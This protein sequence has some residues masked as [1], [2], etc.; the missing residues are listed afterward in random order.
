MAA[1]SRV[2]TAATLGSIPISTEEKISTGKVVWL[3]LI[4]KI[5]TGT[6]SSEAGKMPSNETIAAMGQFNEQLVN[7]G[8]LIAGLWLGTDHAAAW[9]NENLLLVSPFWWLTLPAWLVLMR[10]DQVSGRVARVAMLGGWLAFAGIALG[11]LVKVFRSFDQANIEWLLLLWP[12]VLA[13]RHVLAR[14]CV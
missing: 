8:V 12:L 14:R 13:M 6:L 9:R 4:R 1:I 3:A 7:A 5:V 10:R 11:A 2:E